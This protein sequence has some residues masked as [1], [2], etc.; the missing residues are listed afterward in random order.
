MTRKQKGEK[1]KEW[2]V[3]SHGCWPSLTPYLSLFLHSHSFPKGFLAKE[4][5]S[6]VKKLAILSTIRLVFPIGFQEKKIMCNVFFL[7][8]LWLIRH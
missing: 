7:Y 6:I 8:V 1:A 5:E 3:K 2:E 4:E